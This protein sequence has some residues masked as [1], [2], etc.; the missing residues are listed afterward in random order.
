MKTPDHGIDLIG[1]GKMKTQ[2]SPHIHDYV[3]KVVLPTS[4]LLKL[5]LQVGVVRILGV[6]S[7][8]IVLKAC[9]C[10]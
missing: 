2:C 5:Q 10:V 1:S 7:A 4:T 9:P 3:H 6:S 8:R